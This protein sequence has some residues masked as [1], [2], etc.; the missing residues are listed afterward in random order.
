MGN[1]GFNNTAGECLR[2]RNYE[3]LSY[4]NWDYW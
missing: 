2:K 3:V 4:E 1:K